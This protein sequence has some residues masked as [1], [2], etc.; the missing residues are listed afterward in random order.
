MVSLKKIFGCLK[1]LSL[2]ILFLSAGRL[3]FAVDL[4]PDLLLCRTGYKA[5]CVDGV[6][7]CVEDSVKLCLSSCG[8]PDIDIETCTAGDIQ[9]K[10]SGSCGTSERKCCSGGTWSGWDSECPKTCDNK[11]KPITYQ[12]CTASNGKRG[13]QTRTVTCNTSTGTWT[14]GSWGTC[15]APECSF[16]ETK[17]CPSNN[18]Q[19]LTCLSTGKWSSTCSCE[20]GRGGGKVYCQGMPITTAESNTCYH[21]IWSDETC[22]GICCCAGDIPKLMSTGY[23]GCWGRN[24]NSKNGI[25]LWKPS[26][27]CQTPGRG[28][29]L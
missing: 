4:N 26:C 25:Y 19:V 6:M 5:C 22:S 16:G 29:V 11:S 21:G 12:T 1:V 27:E 7:K 20:G 17:V 28:T 3:S 10:P 14:T 23:P 13:T 8:T 9:Y 18:K 2:F 24:N 15:V